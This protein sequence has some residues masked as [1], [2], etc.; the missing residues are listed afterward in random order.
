MSEPKVTLVMPEGK[1]EFLK[2]VISGHKDFIH[3][4]GVKPLVKDS[5]MK[6]AHIIGTII[7]SA[8]K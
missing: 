2:N 1:Y 7:S 3:K 4:L 6:D 8:K 5:L